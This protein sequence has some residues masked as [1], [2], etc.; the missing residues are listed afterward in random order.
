[1]LLHFQRSKL[2]AVTMLAMVAVAACS[3]GVVAP[4][5]A[6]TASPTLGQTAEPPAYGPWARIVEGT[7]GPG[8]LYAIYVPTRWNRQTVTVAH[9]FRDAS[10]PVDLRDQDGL[11][12][13][14]DALGALGYAVAYS[15]YSENGFAVKDGAQRTHQLRGLLAS[16]LP[17]TPTKNYLIGYSLGGGV[18][19]TLAEKF[20]SQ[21]DGALLV[22]G[23]VGGSR[24]QTQ[25][26]GHVR[27]LADA[28]FPGMLPGNV[29]GVPANTVINPMT[30]IG[31]IA[32]NPANQ[33][34]LLAMASTAQTPLPIDPA[35]FFPSLLES[36]IT[37][38]S[39]HARGIN[40]IV[41][42]THGFSPFGNTSTVYSVGTPLL[43]AA[44]L[45]PLL[46]LANATVTRYAIDPAAEQYLSHNFTPSGDLRIPVLTV[47]NAYDPAVPVQHET[48]LLNAVMTAGATDFLSQRVINR[49]GHCK[50]NAAEISDAFG[51]LTSW[52]ATGVKPA[53]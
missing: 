37:G 29:L 52:V 38:V 28:Y 8:T 22:C 36:L 25:Y 40:N 9:G 23:M 46:Q 1:M 44:A 33:A 19:L 4:S 6:V 50:V 39:F 26:L 27:A 30:I 34:K 24:V 32:P 53:P 31:T 42:L 20:S 12:A 47:H 2:A 49:Y 11:Y 5:A 48:A 10:T 51:D 18:A 16:N 14:R 13:T 45:T 15:S 17:A 7:T 41:E 21:Y 43:P 3:D 35:N